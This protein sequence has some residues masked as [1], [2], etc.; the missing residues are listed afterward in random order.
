M[1]AKYKVG[2][3]CRIVNYGHLLWSY[4]DMDLPIYAKDSEGNP[5]WY[6]THSEYIG[7]KVVIQSIR[8]S[9]NSGIQYSTSLFSWASEEQ[10]QLI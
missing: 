6:D 5:N 9:D 2:D 3:K 10:L 8:V 1:K 7:K 4:Y